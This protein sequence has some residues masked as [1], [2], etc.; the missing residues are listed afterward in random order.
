MRIVS[1]PSELFFLLCSSLVFFLLRF[2]S[3][4]EPHWYGDE[5][6]YQAIGYA[7]NNGRELYST[8][9]DNKPPLLYVLYAVF[10]SDQFTLRSLSLLAGISSIIA[11]FFLAKKIY[12]T[13]NGVIVSTLLFS[14][15]FALPTFEGGIQREK[16]C[17]AKWRHG[18]LCCEA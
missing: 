6:I 11:F 14:I 12:R 3:L 18:A 5:G 17:I 16:I 9:W 15:L 13:R 4:F 7:L 8:I 2:P 1:K 10:N